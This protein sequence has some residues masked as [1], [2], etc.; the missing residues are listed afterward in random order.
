M[1]GFFGIEQSKE[2]L[3]ALDRTFA[4]FESMPAEDF[5]AL[6]VEH[7][8]G[9]LAKFISLGDDINASHAQELKFVL[10]PADHSLKAFTAFFSQK[11]TMCF[12]VEGK[13]SELQACTGASFGYASANVVPVGLITV[14]HNCLAA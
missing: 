14:A 6:G 8:S 7:S 11:S 5:F 10:E 3:D 13:T 2:F 9:E 12:E 4:K 1:K